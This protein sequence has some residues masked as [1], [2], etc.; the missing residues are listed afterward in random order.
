[1]VGTGNFEER[2]NQSISHPKKFGFG[3]EVDTIKEEEKK[4]KKV[5]QVS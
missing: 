3:V 4:E 2:R 5:V 1:M